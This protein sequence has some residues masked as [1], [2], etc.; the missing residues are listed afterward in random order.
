[1]V[2]DVEVEIKDKEGNALAGIQYLNLYNNTQKEKYDLKEGAG[3]YKVSSLPVISDDYELRTENYPVGRKIKI[4]PGHL[5]VVSTIKLYFKIEGAERLEVFRVP[6]QPFPPYEPEISKPGHT[7][8]W[9]KDEQYSIPMTED[10]WNKTVNDFYGKYIYGRWESDPVDPDPVEP[11]PPYVPIYYSVYL[12]QVEGAV[13][14]PGPGEY[15]VES[16]STFRFYLTLDSAYSESQ[17]VVT[18]DRGETLQ[19]RTSDG[20]YLVKYV[21]TDVEVF[22]DGI[23]QN[24]PPVANEAIAPADALAPQIWAEGTMLC[25]RM[26]EA[27]PATPVSIFTIVGSC[28]RGCIL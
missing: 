17:P 3:R 21:R 14:D 1:M 18:T 2:C 16:W 13:T 24:P 10:D 4:T 28:R 6:G 15:E 5:V 20:A 12:P 9:Y 11:D 19:P 25:I 8:K 22:I 23:V 27:L 7:L 26:P